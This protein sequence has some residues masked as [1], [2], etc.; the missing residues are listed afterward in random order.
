MI[1]NIVFDFGGVLVEL[2]KEICVNSYKRLGMDVIAS[3]VNDYRS[4]DLFN[5]FELGK[6]DLHQFCEEARRQSG[7]YAT[8]EEI[9]QAWLDLY[10]GLPQWKLDKVLEL[11]KDFR[12][13]LLSN[14]NPFHWEYACREYFKDVNRY[15]EKIYLS[16]ELG[17]TKPDREIFEY[18]I[19]DSG[20]NPDETLFLDD[21]KKNCIGAES[22]GI[23]AWHIAER[24]DWSKRDFD[25]LKKK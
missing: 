12:I 10:I 15:F 21:S 20:I 7:V 13:L 5:D 2:D 19:N 16:Y 25:S 4:E 17:M 6:I 3:Y 1:R 23:H 8:D 11:K 24:E 22:L 14:M 9:T 18:M